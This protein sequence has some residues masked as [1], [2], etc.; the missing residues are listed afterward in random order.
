MTDSDGLFLRAALA[1]AET[2]WIQTTPNPSVGCLIVKDGQVLGRGWTGRPGEGHA[3]V[4]AL[5]DARERV[6]AEGIRGATAYV[7][8]EPCAFH[9]RTPP[10]AEA[11]V[12]AGIARVVGA[13][14][15]P[16]P[17]VAGSGYGQLEAAGVIVDRHELPEARAMVAGFLSRM[18]TG[19][20]RVRIKIAA[21]LDGRTA[22]ASGESQWVTGDAARADVQGLRARSCAIITGSQ[23]VRLDN[24]ALTVRHPAY[25]YRDEIRQ[26]L[27]VVLDSAAKLPGDAKIFGEP[28]AALVVHSSGTPSH[29][30]AEFLNLP[31]TPAGGIDLG[32][33]L[34]ALG[35][36][37]CN[38]VL[39]ETGPILAGAFLDAGLWDELVVYLAPKLLGSDARPLARL[40][41]AR[42]IDAIEAKIADRAELGDDIRLRLVP[43]DTAS[44]TS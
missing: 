32:A 39:V 16:H 26:P 9:G 13:L 3:E 29:D 25:R 43:A 1:L 41:I 10:C 24:P 18:L 35:E 38:E 36:R 33:L 12:N 19:R 34:D 6:G 21:S 5:Q 27:R 15:D 23:T 14:T 20:P 31:A 17:K 2:G 11:L 42:M 28:G 7:S 37:G 8:L 44:H 22:M 40:P 4:H 30:R